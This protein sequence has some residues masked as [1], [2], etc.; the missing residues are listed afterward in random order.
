MEANM[1]EPDL[2][3]WDTVYP[4][5]P[6]YRRTATSKAAAEAM[7]TRA[8]T[9]K[10]RLLALLSQGGEYTPDEAAQAL[11]V[12]VLALRP[13]FSELDRLGKIVPTGERRPNASGL[14]AQVYRISA[15][16]GGTDGR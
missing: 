10:E 16:Y 11:G 13:R 5:A 2:F 15:Y 6:A 1:T 7:K 9:L 4:N 14:K 3:N 8:P 12:T